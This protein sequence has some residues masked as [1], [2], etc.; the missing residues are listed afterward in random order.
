MLER[1]L[2]IVNAQAS[3]KMQ[4]LNQL[5]KC[6]RPACAF[7]PF[8]LGSCGEAPGG[9]GRGVF[10]SIKSDRWIREQALTAE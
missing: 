6:R 9:L 5:K 10:L 7:R 8:S 3:R 2:R 1:F 4:V